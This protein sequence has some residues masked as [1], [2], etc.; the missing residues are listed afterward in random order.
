[1]DLLFSMHVYTW[2]VECNVWIHRCTLIRTLKNWKELHPEDEKNM[3][4][5]SEVRTTSSN[6]VGD[7]IHILLAWDFF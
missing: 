3:Q 2:Q 6:Y 4:V 1:M 5:K 7:R